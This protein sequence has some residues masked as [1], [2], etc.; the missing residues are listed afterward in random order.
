[1]SDNP[2]IHKSEPNKSN[3]LKD[4]FEALVIAVTINVV[5]YFL[6]IIPSQVEGP[7]MMPNLKDQELLFANKTPTWFNSNREILDRF[8]W[9]YQRGDIVI[10]DFNDIVLVKRVIAG[11]GDSIYVSDGEVYVNDKKIYETYLAVDTKT[12]IPQVGLRFLAESE[13][14]TVPEGYFFVM[15]DNRTQSKD[16]RY[17]DVGFVAREQIKGVVFFRFWPLGS[18]GPIGRGDYRAEE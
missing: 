14:I 16:S 3:I 10:F 15:G 11:G 9:D 13:K 8:N 5:I 4:I 2:F 6:F 12:E 17:E 1:M 7:S 18:F